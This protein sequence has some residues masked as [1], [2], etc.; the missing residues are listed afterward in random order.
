MELVEIP[1]TIM[2][3]GM[4][5]KLRL[6]RPEYRSHTVGG[7][8]VVA[9]VVFYPSVQHLHTLS[10]TLSLSSDPSDSLET[11][12]NDVAVQAIK[13]MET[14]HK[15][16]LRDFSYSEMEKKKKEN[17]F[18]RQQL[19]KKDKEIGQK[20]EQLK[21]ATKSWGGLINKMCNS[22]QRI[23]KIISENLSPGYSTQHDM[24][25]AA[26][27]DIQATSLTIAQLTS[28]ATRMFQATEIY[29]HGTQSDVT[30]DEHSPG[31]Y[32]SDVDPWNYSSSLPGGAYEHEE[33]FLILLFF[34]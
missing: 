7:G 12:A 6:P 34:P 27:L 26:L 21:Q 28:E 8:R 17:E 11:A 25:S 15:K 30:A 20:D 32:G 18:L 22:N 5:K 9:I 24:R 2:L 33:F 19:T 14:V 31:F 29:L 3:A 4:L 23:Q 13:Y 1:A 10:N 16:V